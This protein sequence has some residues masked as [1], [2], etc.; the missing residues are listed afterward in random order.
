M[1]KILFAFLGMMLFWSCDDNSKKDSLQQGKLELNIR[2]TVEGESLITDSLIYINAAGNQYEISEIQWF[3]SD[4]YLHK[5]DGSTVLMDAENDI[6]YIDTDIESSWTL[7]PSTAIAAGAYAGLSFTFGIN[8]EKNKSLRFVNPPES[9]MFWPDYLGGG[10]H[11]MK[12]NGKWINPQ[13]QTE[14]F[15]FH[16]GIGQIYDST[17]TKSS[18]LN[19]DSCCSHN[20]CKGYQPPKKMMPIIGFVQ[21]YFEVQLNHEFTI[22]EGKMTQLDLIMQIEQWFEGQHIYDH[23]FWGGSIMQQQ[24]AMKMAC[25]NGLKVFDLKLKGVQDGSK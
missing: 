1:K 19:L 3:L 17:A 6:S 5:A 2:H 24:A 18:Y 25:E 21:N 11:Y 7:R 16:L 22:Y 10:Y 15:N 9:F 14:P 8:E 4:I 12:L 20:H 13:G 23:N